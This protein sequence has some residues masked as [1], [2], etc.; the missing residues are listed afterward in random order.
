MRQITLK[1]I[2][3]LVLIIGSLSAIFILL[4]GQKD[5]P[6]EELKTKYTNNS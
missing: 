1:I 6:L 4:F 3:T 5:I 2:K